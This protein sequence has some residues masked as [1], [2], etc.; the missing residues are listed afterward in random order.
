MLFPV[1]AFRL[2]VGGLHVGGCGKGP[3]ALVT[4][5]K[6]IRK[7]VRIINKSFLLL[8]N[9]FQGFW[10]GLLTTSGSLARVVGPIFVAFIYKVKLKNVILLCQKI[11]F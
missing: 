2:H 3:W 6:A 11:A 9:S 4:P 1:V 10:M 8:I 5:V 7:G